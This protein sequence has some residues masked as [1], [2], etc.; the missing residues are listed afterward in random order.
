MSSVC[1]T[2]RFGSGDTVPNTQS[3]CPSLL[4]RQSFGPAYRPEITTCTGVVTDA[5]AVPWA[6]AGAAFQAQI[7]SKAA[8]MTAGRCGQRMRCRQLIVGGASGATRVVRS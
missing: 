1:Q 2:M 6:A 4:I 8:V 7:S 5:T 3:T